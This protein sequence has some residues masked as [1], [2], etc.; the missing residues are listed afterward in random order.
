MPDLNDPKTPLGVSRFQ[1]IVAPDGTRSSAA[2]AWLGPKIVQSRKNL[3]IL[4]GT[5]VTRLISDDDD[6]GDGKVKVLGV[7]VA[8][9]RDGP[10]YVARAKHEVI[11]SQGAYGTPQLLLLS[12]IGPREQLESLG[13]KTR[14][15]LA[16]V[17]ARARDH[18]MASHVFKVKPGTS[19]Q[20]LAHPLKVLPSLIRWLIWGDGPLR[21]NLA[22][23][24]AFVRA[25]EQPTAGQVATLSA[26]ACT[27][28]GDGAPDLELITAPLYYLL[29][30][31]EA[32]KEPQ[33]DY[34][35]IAPVV[36]RP[37]SEG[38]ITLKSAD[39]FDKAVIDPAF[40]KTE[41]DKKV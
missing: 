13:I 27:A 18:P 32:P 12:G 28:S 41:H 2:A 17:G 39:P 14:L 7:E 29:P 30:T 31:G 23:A 21:T 33:D 34:I 6:E 1:S 40:L 8:Q 20:Y 11:V 3:D 35:S 16:G 22:E 15:D 5:T 36:L 37:T 38:S 19:L 9:S 10:R 4:T 24:G 25:H 26:Q